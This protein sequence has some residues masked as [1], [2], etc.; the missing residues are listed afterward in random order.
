M[1]HKMNI[2]NPTQWTIKCLISKVWKLHFSDL[3]FT[4]CLDELLDLGNSGGATHQDDLVHL[5]LLQTRVLQHLPLPGACHWGSRGCDQKTTKKHEVVEWTKWWTVHPNK[6]HCLINTT[7]WGGQLQ[8]LQLE[9]RCMHSN[10]HPSWIPDVRLLH[11]S[12]SVLEE[13][14]V[15]LLTGLTTREPLVRSNYILAT[16][17][18]P[19]SHLPK[20]KVIQ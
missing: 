10:Q 7:F 16:N 12:Q 13:I 8:N 4:A 1:N 18:R 5:V 11:R 14:R 19:S 15:Q 20:R 2:K 6:R 9:V 17:H 3:S